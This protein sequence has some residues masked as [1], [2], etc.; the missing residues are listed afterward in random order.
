[1]RSE[2]VLE[3]LF[4]YSRQLIQQ[5]PLITFIGA[6]ILTHSVESELKV[7]K[8]LPEKLL[9]TSYFTHRWIQRWLHTFSES[10]SREING[11]NLVLAALTGWP[12]SE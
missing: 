10:L 6:G 7:K 11:N 9:V 4:D 3:H 8:C 2:A 12:L 1:M 5:R